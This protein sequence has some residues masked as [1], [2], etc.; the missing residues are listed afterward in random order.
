MSLGGSSAAA[1]FLVA[2]G[3]A[4][5]VA[6]NGANVTVR[7]TADLVTSS[8][9]NAGNS[10]STDGQGLLAESIGGGGGSGGWSATGSVTLGTSGALD[11]GAAIG[12]SGRAGG[13]AGAVDVT[14]N[15][16][17]TTHGPNSEGIL[18]ASLGGGGGNA[19]GIANLTVARSG[20]G[21]LSVVGSVNIGQSGGGGGTANNVTVNSTGA[22]TTQG[23]LSSAISA[24]SGGGGGG[25]A[26]YIANLNIAAGSNTGTLTGSVTLGGS[27]GTGQAAKSV[28][29]TANGALT[30][31]GDDSPGILA[32]SIGG[33]GGNAANT[34]SLTFGQPSSGQKSLGLTAAVGGSGGA[35]AGALAATVTNYGDI[36]TS[37]SF[38]HG[39]EAQSV[40]GGGG[41]AA[42]SVSTA[43][44]TSS[45][46]SVTVGGSGSA[47]ANAGTVDVIN[48]GAIMLTG[49]DAAGIIASSVGGG[50]GD[51]QATL[52]GVGASNTNA[53]K[54]GFANVSV[55]NSGAG[56]G[57]GGPV[58]VSNTGSITTS[59][60]PSST[61]PPD[62]PSLIYGA[63]LNSY[64]I[65][66][67]SVGGG[68]GGGG[69]ATSLVPGIT[70]AQS[71]LGMTVTVGGT[72]GGGGIGNAVRVNNSGSI[73]TA[74]TD[75]YG[76]LAQSVGGG[77]GKGGVAAS[78]T[79]FLQNSSNVLNIGVA[80]GG[81]GG[82]GASS[83]PVTV[84]N[85]A[86]IDTSGD[87]SHAIFAQSVGG[88]GGDGGSAFAYALGCP[89]GKCTSSA[90]TTL[91][92]AVGGTGGSGGSSNTVQVTNDQTIKTSGDG[93]IGIFGQSVGGGG[94]TGGNGASLTT[95]PVSA[96]S[97]DVGGVGGAS[98][99]GGA[100]SVNQRH[101]SIET[102][103]A[104]AAGI[105][106]QSVGG[107][108]GRGGVGVFANSI[109][110]L[111]LGGQG[112]ASGNGGRVDAGV[113]NGSIVT[114]GSGSYGVWAQSVG[115]GGGQA[116]G[117][118]VGII[119]SPVGSPPPNTIG[120]VTGRGSAPVNGTGA[121]AVVTA[122]LDSSFVST[123]GSDAIG[124]FAQSVGGGGGVSGQNSANCNSNCSYIV[125]STGGTG[126]GGPVDVRLLN[127]SITTTGQFSHG[128]F[129]QSAGGQGSSAGGVAVTV[130]G[131]VSAAG[132]G[133]SG[134]FADS[135][136]GG[137]N[138]N[139]SIFIGANSTVSGGSGNAAGVRLID[140]AANTLTNGGTITT[141][142]GVN[143]VA[144]RTDGGNLTINNTGSIIGGLDVNDG[145]VNAAGGGFLARE[146]II[147]TGQII[148][149]IG[150][151]NQASVT[152]S[153][154][155][156]NKFGRLS[157]GAINIANGNLAFA[158]GNTDLGDN[159]AVNGGA[160]KVTNF[161][162]LR[163]GA[164]ETV[165]GNF[166][167]TGSGVFDSLI[168]GDASDRYGALT[169]T[170]DAT[171]QGHLALD[172]TNGF[173]L[174]AGDSFDLFNF[175]DSSL[176]SPS[177]DLPL[178]FDGAN[179]LDEDGDIW[180]CSD[181]GSLDLMETISA[182]SL[183]INVV[184]RPLVTEAAANRAV[185][186][187]P[188]LVMFTTCLLGL[189]G[190]GTLRRRHSTPATPAQKYV[191][192]TPLEINDPAPLMRFQKGST[193][194]SVVSG[195]RDSRHTAGHHASGTADR[196]L[197]SSGR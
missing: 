49:N 120:V 86:K 8:P 126:N 169:V 71:S 50:G 66:A 103:G 27:G 137:N 147:N 128:I 185:P 56:G 80:V 171:L 59:L 53:G 115:G 168:G 197:L 35:G 84:A 58:I 10:T 190:I 87:G 74:Q 110:Q 90:Q 9:A 28:R 136:G 2:V 111:T 92:V 125:G 156:G 116:G 1:S 145:F 17:I 149:N 3:G 4:G 31:S 195:N 166:F 150:I 196:K 23:Y 163:L 12:A 102:Q 127:G 96:F 5:G 6:G 82:S 32:Q 143:G 109:A 124:L 38:S 57:N 161:G 142:K 101:N 159:I 36:A 62:N 78:V 170:G 139:I 164:A 179:C 76:I 81:R 189:A 20:Q 178:T 176:I 144:V 114:A 69:A 70:A 39:I 192:T 61:P 75:S 183:D 187:P 180:S 51:S 73:I 14:Q 40:G 118:G 19:G 188:S 88:G 132:D 135:S 184:A 100:V 157:G 107:G 30:T 160:G 181:L 68:G 83:G 154:G 186:E 18:A 174:H 47:G 162:V 134:I 60:V 34:F 140:G 64:G 24:Q 94:G 93:A 16:S 108:G 158:G 48:G 42:L 133:A 37:G 15:G 52:V 112:G 122:S 146:R 7:N 141:V 29:I 99:N 55:G 123:T 138:G 151:S 25:D 152:I 119:D 63:P 173:A 155:S 172:L 129:A 131:D 22:I 121:G 54:S 167:Q 165:S 106:A 194:A 193:Q 89:A 79:G 41:S 33:G 43:A 72:G 46:A 182:T 177:D 104:D 117:L 26:G 153:G 65:V 44:F 85:T 11:L 113:N 13:D 91:N 191:E 98:G 97:V 95:F 175:A 45:K 67:Q 21:G 77:G 105:Y 130:K 148:G